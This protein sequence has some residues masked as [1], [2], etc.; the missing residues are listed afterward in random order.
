MVSARIKPARIVRASILVLSAIIQLTFWPAVAWTG[1]DGVAVR[2]CNSSSS[3]IKPAKRPNKKQ[4]KSANAPP[5]EAI[6]CLEVHA[7]TLEIQEFI[8]SVVRNEQWKLTDQHA[9]EEAL[10]F[11]R[12]LQKDELL[13]YTKSDRKRDRVSWTGGRAFIQAMTSEVADGFIRIEIL[14][15]F[16]GYGQSPDQFAPPKESWPL[17]SNGSLE[18]ALLTAVENHFKSIH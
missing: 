3:E 13:D 5:A 18:K 8:E 7:A 9:A 11:V 12:H 10:T 16:L 2:A 15:S 1:T 6:A 14:A 17:D 4:G